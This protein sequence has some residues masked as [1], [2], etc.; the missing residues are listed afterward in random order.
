[1]TTAQPWVA[2]ARV[3]LADGDGATAGDVLAYLRTLSDNP[4]PLPQ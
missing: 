1:M 4:V 2:A 3:A